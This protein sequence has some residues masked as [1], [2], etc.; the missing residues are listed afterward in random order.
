MDNHNHDHEEV[1]LDGIS[2]EVE[3]L[4]SSEIKLKVKV[5]G[6]HYT[7]AHNAAYKVLAA[8]TTVAGFRPGKAPRNLIEARLGPRLLEETLNVLLPRVTT[9]VVSKEKLTPLNTVKYDLTKF[10]LDGD[11]EYSAEFSILPEVELPDFAKISG[12]KPK[13]NVEDSEVDELFTRL[14]SE[15]IAEQKAKED[16]A[17]REN[18]KEGEAELKEEAVEIDWSKELGMPEVKTEDEV[19]AKLKANILS[20]KESEAEDQYNTDIVKKVIESSKIGAPAPLVA[21]LISAKEGDYRKRIEDLGLKFE[22]FLKLQKT[23][24]AKL[25]E[26]WKADAEFQV[27]TDVLFVTVA[28]TYELKV[29]AE[30]IDTEIAKIEDPKL[31]ADYDSPQGREYIASTLLRQ[32]A[33]QKILGL[34]KKA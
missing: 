4:T 29:M 5:G 17:E 7:E 8:E 3:K 19:R 20:R 21:Q 1:N 32:K 12:E 14:K 30:D 31:K 9:K 33:L 16:T 11:I 27:Q 23:D 10:T 24:L 6:N 34:V 28:K 18:D 25:Q 22:D 26:T 15:I 13:V 2:Y